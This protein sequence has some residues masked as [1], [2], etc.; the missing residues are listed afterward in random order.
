M[1][2]TMLALSLLCCGLLLSAGAAYA[3]SVKVPV[4]KVNA[5]GVGEEIGFVTFTD[6]EDG[7]DIFVELMGLPEGPHGMH[8]HENPSCAPAEQNGKMVA[9]LAAGGHYDPAKSGKH[10][11]PGKGG[12]MGDLPYVTADADG[13]VKTKL[14]AP[15]LQTKDIK[16]RSLMIHAGGDNYSD[17]PPLGGGGAR[18]ACGV[19]N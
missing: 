1:K 5:E 16:G 15:G 14:H 10:A 6:G 18:I 19:I 9:A 12:H 3:D 13:Q 8:V 11:G 17:I 4:N 7:V 2:K